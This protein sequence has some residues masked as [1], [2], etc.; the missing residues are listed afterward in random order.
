MKIAD[1]VTNASV[2]IGM[3][4]MMGVN[5][6]EELEIFVFD[7]KR[8]LLSHTNVSTLIS[9]VFT[10][11]HIEIYKIRETENENIVKLNKKSMGRVYSFKLDGILDDIEVPVDIDRPIMD[12]DNTF[13]P[14][15]AYIEDNGTMI[16][17]LHIDEYYFQSHD[18][19]FVYDGNR[20]LN[21]NSRLHAKH[22]KA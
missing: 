1:L 13:M 4:R 20:W 19:K 3:T 5:N 16:V 11:K 17:D 18:M 14:H 7:G 21:I 8:K 12:V 22:M 9:V 10:D 2:G 6:K 15:T